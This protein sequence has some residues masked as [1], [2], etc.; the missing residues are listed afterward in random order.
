MRPEA[1]NP[2]T[3]LLS[4]RS[5]VTAEWA[6]EYPR[7]LDVCRYRYEIE[8]PRPTLHVWQCHDERASEN[9]S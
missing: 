7:D 1:A 6:T 4:L 9:W 5:A 3:K 8:E 2:A